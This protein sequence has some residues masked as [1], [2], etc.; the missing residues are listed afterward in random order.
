MKLRH[1]LF[2]KES[3]V[4]Y[5]VSAKP[6]ENMLCPGVSTWNDYS[7]INLKKIKAFSARKLRSKLVE[8]FSVIIIVLSWKNG[9]T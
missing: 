8:H 3:N 4:V 6:Q 9:L 5:L 7:L 1:K 2:N